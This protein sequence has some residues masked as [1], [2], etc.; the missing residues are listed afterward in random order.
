MEP[1][2]SAGVGGRRRRHAEGRTAYPLSEGNTAGELPSHAPGQ[3]W[4]P[5]R[6]HWRQYRP[7]DGMRLQTKLR[8]QKNVAKLPLKGADTPPLLRRGVAFAAILL[9]VFV[10]SLSA[11]SDARLID[12]I[13]AH[14]TAAVRALLKARADVNATQGDGATALHWAARYDDLPAVDLLLRAGA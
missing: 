2:Y 3:V 8:H 1:E 7:A 10:V 9:S 14:D 6:P 13:K 12:A 5:A 11:A 4:N